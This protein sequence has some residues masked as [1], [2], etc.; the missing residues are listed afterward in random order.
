MTNPT[1]TSPIFPHRRSLHFVH[2]A[3]GVPFVRARNPQ[4]SCLRRSRSQHHSRL[5][6]R[7][8]NKIQEVFCTAEAGSNVPCILPHRLQGAKP[9]TLKGH[10]RSQR[11]PC[12]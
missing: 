1:T 5:S 12:Y 3:P 6:N 11:R 7:E 4:T 2:Q 10:T 8:V 9:D